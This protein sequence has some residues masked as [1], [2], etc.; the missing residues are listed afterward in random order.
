LQQLNEKQALTIAKLQEQLSETR[1]KLA[2]VSSTLTDRFEAEKADLKAASEASFAQ[3]RK[4]L[5]S[6]RSDLQEVS[7]LL[8]ESQ[9]TSENLRTANDQLSKQN[10][11]LKTDLKAAKS[12]QAKEK[13]LSELSAAASRVAIENEYTQKFNELKTR[14]EAEKRRLYGLGAEAFNRFFNPLS[15]LDERSFRS[16]VHQAREELERLTAADLAIR[17]LVNAS[18]HQTTEDAVARLVIRPL[19]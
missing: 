10:R 19:N 6:Q 9:A 7:A 8:N 16:V 14:T 2:K 17:R 4:E 11:K 5:E 3:L 13:R 18:E 12:A 15:E 1:E